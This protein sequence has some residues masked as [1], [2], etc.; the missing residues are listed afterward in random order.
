MAIIALAVALA[1]SWMPGTGRA[2]LKAVTLETAALLRRERL[3]AMLVQQE[4]EVFLDRDHRSIIGQGGGVVSVPGDVGLKI[5]GAEDSRWGRQSI[6][7]FHADGASSGAVLTLSREEVNYEI[8][9]NWFTGA[10]AV[11]PQ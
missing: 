11:G 2:G 3:A 8:R 6:V 9:V 5:L 7:R 1:L 10:V 4:R